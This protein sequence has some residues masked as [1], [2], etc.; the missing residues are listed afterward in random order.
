MIDIATLLSEHINKLNNINLVDKSKQPND[1]IIHHLYN[2]GTVTRQKGG[3][4]YKQRSMIDLL[5]RNV[6]DDA[7]FVFNE[8][9]SNE[10]ETY[11]VLD[12]DS[13]LDLRKLM[14]TVCKRRDRINAGLQVL[15]DHMMEITSANFRDTYLH[16]YATL[17][18]G[19]GCDSSSGINCVCVSDT[20]NDSVS[21]SDCYYEKL[22]TCLGENFGTG[23][24][25]SLHKNMCYVCLDITF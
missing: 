11:V 20:D 18:H 4:A 9:G 1:N 21:V 24:A 13:C 16:I 19:C 17:S 5:P 8:R 6:S 3:W 7:V 22:T 23:I 25:W 15:S 12:L 10:G 2:D 14:K